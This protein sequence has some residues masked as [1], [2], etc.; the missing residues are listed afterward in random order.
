LPCFFFPISWLGGSISAYFRAAA[1]FLD[2]GSGLSGV[3]YISVS[4]VP[5]SCYLRER[6]CMGLKKLC[7]GQLQRYGAKEEWHLGFLF[8]SARLLILFLLF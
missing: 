8:H 3:F 5:L 1:N 6:L 7:S 4:L 2:I